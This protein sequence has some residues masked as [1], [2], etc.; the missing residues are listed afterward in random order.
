[1]CVFVVAYSAE[2]T[3]HVDISRPICNIGLKTVFRVKYRGLRVFLETGTLLPF[4]CFDS[5]LK[6][7]LSS[8]LDF[9]GT[10]SQAFFS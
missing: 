1:M 3:V 6:T 8:T 9:L 2:L 5:K 4:Y 7:I 10:F